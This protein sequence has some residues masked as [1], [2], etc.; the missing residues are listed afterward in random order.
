MAQL[1]KLKSAIKFFESNEKQSEKKENELLWSQGKQNVDREFDQIMKKFSD[2]TLDFIVNE[3]Y[4]T[5]IAI[6]INDLNFKG[7]YFYF[8]FVL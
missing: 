7:Y 3:T 1:D 6:D 5:N 2:A 8:T 4:Y